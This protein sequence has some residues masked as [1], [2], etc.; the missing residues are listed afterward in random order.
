METLARQSS[1]SQMDPAEHSNTEAMEEMPT[2]S[3][4]KYNVNDTA[5]S[6]SK[7]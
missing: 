1:L 4:L 2:A 5:V 6:Y 3:Q 7:N